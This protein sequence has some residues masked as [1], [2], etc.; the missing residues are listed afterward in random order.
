MKCKEG[1]PPGG[2]ADEVIILYPA[3]SGGESDL[4]AIAS[5]SQKDR[6]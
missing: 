5:E 6:D 4:S 3:S 1:E 2:V